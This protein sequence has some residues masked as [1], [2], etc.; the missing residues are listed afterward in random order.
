MIKTFFKGLDKNKVKVFLLFLTFSF[1]SWAV[2]K[3]S[4]SYDSWT[5]IALTPINLP[6][7]L[8]M[9]HAKNLDVKLLLRAN[10]FQL[11]GMGL[12]NNKLKV[13]VSSVSHRQNAYYITAGRAQRQLQ[14]SIA[15]SAQLLD[16]EP[17]TLYFNLYKVA[18]KKVPVVANVDIQLMPNHLVKDGFKI[19]PDSVIL[20]GPA[21]DLDSITKIG[22]EQMSLTNVDNN[23]SVSLA[24]PNPKYLSNAELLTTK[25]L[26]SGTVVGFSEKIFEIPVVVDNIP[27]GFTV[28]TFPKYVSLLC[29]ATEEDLIRL[30][31]MD[32]EVGAVYD[33]VLTNNEV[34]ALEITEYPASALSVRLLQDSV[35]FLLEP[36]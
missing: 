32:F 31:E 35:D 34:L 2:S 20:K 12:G 33:P 19:T 18:T 27:Q 17:D 5:T 29:K 23:F 21:Q 26:V 22:T 9:D 10:G 36:K 14:R 4:Q 30:S 24:L 28:R 6:D 1:L 13:D 7:S 8:F 11:V 16:I 25:V 3:L 15:G